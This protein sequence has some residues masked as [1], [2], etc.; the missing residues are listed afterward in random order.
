MIAV[1]ISD[2]SKKRRA[3][4]R[5]N[6][7]AIAYRKQHADV[8]NERNKHVRN[9]V[10]GFRYQV[11]RRGDCK[12]HNVPC[13]NGVP[14]TEIYGSYNIAEHLKFYVKRSKYKRVTK[15]IP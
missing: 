1:F 3:E 7:R 6:F 10:F 4:K 2:V 12:K 8:Q 5:K 11:K 13:E 15:V 9:G 14:P